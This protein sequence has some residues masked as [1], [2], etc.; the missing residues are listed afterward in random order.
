MIYNLQYFAEE[1]TEETPTD[2]TPTEEETVDIQALAELVAEKDKQITEC[3]AEIAKLKRTNA[4]MLVQINAGSA[5]NKSF[6]EKMLELA[7]DKPR[8]E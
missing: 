6:D 8:K 2:E 5:S 7:G 4:Q 3:M 1:E